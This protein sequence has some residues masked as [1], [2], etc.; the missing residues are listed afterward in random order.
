MEDRKLMAS[1][2]FSTWEEE[3]PEAIQFATFSAT[4]SRSK[5]ANREWSSRAWI[6]TPL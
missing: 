3:K 5:V 6:T 4:W 2:A 1:L